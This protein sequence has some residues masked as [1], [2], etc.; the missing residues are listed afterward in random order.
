M[1][2]V[3]AKLLQQDGCDCAH[4]GCSQ[5]GQGCNEAT[6]CSWGPP[7]PA[8]VKSH[9]VRT[10]RGAGAPRQGGRHQ[11]LTFPHPLSHLSPHHA[12]HS[13]GLAS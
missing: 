12:A 3:L 7:A 5:P 9:F 11:N 10:A 2:A 6:F 8:A 13:H 1:D 4:G